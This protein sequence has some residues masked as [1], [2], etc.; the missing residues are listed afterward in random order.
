MVIWIVNIYVFLVIHLKHPHNTEK[1]FK[2]V[3]K[4]FK[5]IGC[6]RLMQ[7]LYFLFTAKIKQM[8][9]IVKKRL[10]LFLKFF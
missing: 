8:I 3:S 1:C 7:M 9:V 6:F 5:R 10:I 2:Y 4:Y